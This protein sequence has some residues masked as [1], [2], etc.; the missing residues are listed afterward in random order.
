MRQSSKKGLYVHNGEWVGLII[1]AN[2][3]TKDINQRFSTNWK[4]QIRASIH[5][6]PHS[7]INKNQQKPVDQS[8]ILDLQRSDRKKRDTRQD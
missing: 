8:G 5:Q 1:H 3:T 6:S 4:V 2:W 7:I